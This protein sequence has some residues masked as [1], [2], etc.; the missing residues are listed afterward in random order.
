MAPDRVP[1]TP[2][3]IRRMTVLGV[4]CA[5]LLALF[6]GRPVGAEADK[7]TVYAI[8]F[9]TIAGFP[10]SALVAGGDRAV[11]TDLAMSVWLLKGADG[12]IALVDTGF[13]REQYFRQFAV[14]DYVS[15]ADALAGTGVAADEITD[16][17]LSHMH[18]DHAGGLDLFPK[19]RVWVQKDEYDHYVGDAWQSRTGHGG[20]D[21]DDVVEL[22]RRNTA[23]LVTFVRGED[24]TSISG[25]EFHVGGRHTWASQY[26]TVATKAGT[27]VIA[28]DNA[29]LYENLDNRLAIAQTLDPASNLKAQERM[30]ALA[31]RPE[32]VVPGHDPLVFSRF[33]RVS[34]R[35]VRVE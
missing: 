28:S 33:P 9:A 21:A 14:R 20:V 24:D 11:K 31:A 26:V 27:V 22:V 23:G 29:Y 10:K 5:A 34:D 32:L 2:T 4:A 25:I 12:R 1:W 35:I 18:W 13:H 17:I 30:R 3:A 19:A 6:G 15:P 16:I 8:R 7:Y